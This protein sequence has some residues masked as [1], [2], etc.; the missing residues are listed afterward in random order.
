MSSRIL[1]VSI[2]TCSTPDPVFPLGL[3]QLTAALRAAGHEVRWNDVQVPGASIEETLADFRPHYTG[4]SLRNIDDVLIRKQETYFEGLNA[5]CAR[6]RELAGCPVILGGSG[7]S[8][9]PREL[10]EFSGADFGIC[11][12]GDQALVA[13]IS[14]LETRRDFSAVPGLVW[15]QNGEVRINPP[16]AGTPSPELDDADRPAAV[17]DHYLR[18]GGMLNIQ[19]QRGCAFRCCY[20]TYPVIEGRAHLRQPPEQVAEEFAR[21][22]RL[23]AK[24]LFIVDS[25]FNA[26]PGHVVEICEAIIQK[27]VKISWGCFLRPQG[28]TPELMQVMG[29]AGLAHIEFGTDSL[30]D[31][32]L[33]CYQ[34]GF[35]FDDIQRSSELAHRHCIDY[36]HFLIAGGP[37][38]TL[39]TLQEGFE[40]SRRLNGAIIMAV[41]GMRIYPG[42]SLFERALAE[43]R[44]TRETNL[45]KPVYYLA[46][47]LTQEAVFDRLQEFSRLCPNWI[48]GDPA[49]AYARLVERLRQRGI[50]GPLWGYFSMI[51]R[52]WPQGV[53]SSHS[54]APA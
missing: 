16:A 35:T 27:N 18:A 11:G 52:L 12:A 24:Y 17:V 5:L 53:P 10:Y 46:K 47:G 23:G 36:C 19:T 50:V 25:V 31:E 44:V 42:T 1:L 39:E 20:C 41:V 43:G 40:Q 32:V 2:N 21:A 9:F 37:G 6:T 38:E 15:K 7:F 49:P 48:P 13:L 45:L 3:A 30:S 34:K 54:P 33:A 28:L 8:I 4:I 26:T 14:A 51:Q 22:A 29:R